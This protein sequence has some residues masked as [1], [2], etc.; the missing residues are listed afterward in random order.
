MMPISFDILHTAVTF[1][2]FY[3]AIVAMHQTWQL[4]NNK[5]FTGGQ[6]NINERIHPGNLAE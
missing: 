1:K 3:T 5:T 2:H 6:N 4:H